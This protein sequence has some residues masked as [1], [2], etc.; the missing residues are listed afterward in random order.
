MPSL[1]NSNEGILIYRFGP[2]G[3][4]YGAGFQPENSG[5]SGSG[6]NWPK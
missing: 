5:Y 3:D 4:A 1:G 2:I 6:T